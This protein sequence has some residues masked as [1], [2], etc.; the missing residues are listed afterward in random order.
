MN[1]LLLEDFIKETLKENSTKKS[2]IDKNI[3]ASEITWGML[4]DA[5]EDA[6]ND[7]IKEDTLSFLYDKFKLVSPSWVNYTLEGVET[8]YEF[9][10]RFLAQNYNLNG[11]SDSDQNPF[12]ID[13]N[14]S[15]ILKD[16]VEEKFIEALSWEC[17]AYDDNEKIADFDMTEKLQAW[18][19][20]PHG[21]EEYGGANVVRPKSTRK[22]QKLAPWEK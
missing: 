16:E 13:P 3:P 2:S 8:S 14:V 1:K 6:L 10:A 21:K 15:K 4:R 20:S 18:L 5:V 9:I 11:A 17:R 7:D 19:D 12:E 22:K